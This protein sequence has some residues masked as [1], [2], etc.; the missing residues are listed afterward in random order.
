MNSLIS[1]LMPAYNAEKYIAESVES[2][3][4]QDYEN[5][6]LLIADDGSID[7]TVD[8][9]QQFKDSRIRLIQNEKNIGL[10]RTLNKLLDLA[11]GEYI[12]RLDSDDI[13]IPGRFRSQ[14]ESM[15]SDAD[16]VLLGANA[17]FI[18]ESS[19]VINNGRPYISPE[20][21]LS[22]VA[23]RWLM[24]FPENYFI[25][26][27]VM[28]RAT[29]LKDNGL[30]YDLTQRAE[31]VDMW[32]RVAEF[33]K[34]KILSKPLVKYRILDGSFTSKNWK[35]QLKSAR[36]WAQKKREVLLGALTGEYSDNDM[37][38]IARLFHSYRSE[39][40]EK[41]DEMV[42]RRDLYTKLCRALIKSILLEPSA[43]CQF[44]KSVKIIGD[45]P[46]SDV[47]S[48]IPTL[49]MKKMLYLAGTRRKSS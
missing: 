32:A 27:S 48:A 36:Y 49:F 28:L 2:V 42:I 8:I 13:A 25:H 39:I 12:A 16:L 38:L 33:G 14:I 46:I 35:L 11:K 26:S 37:I 3:L 21:D 5:F 43:L 24:L 23:I 20:R 15:E 4:M 45:A 30:R 29:V 7:A 22:D 9:I 47:F 44:K 19:A 6:E 10:T 34:M 17:I 1:V 40:I 31:D 18:D 41:D